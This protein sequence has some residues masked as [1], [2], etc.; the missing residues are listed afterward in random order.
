[1]RRRDI[2]RRR[3]APTS[4]IASLTLREKLAEAIRWA[5]FVVQRGA[6]LHLVNEYERFGSW[7]VGCMHVQ[8]S[9]GTGECG[10]LLPAK[11]SLTVEGRTYGPGTTR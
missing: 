5:L 4:F 8:P 10:E 9:D 7:C 11:V 1:M 3:P 2:R 6:A